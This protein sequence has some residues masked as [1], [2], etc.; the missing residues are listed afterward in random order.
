MRVDEMAPPA[1]L[2]SPRPLTR[3][4]AASPA[5]RRRSSVPRRSL[6]K[7]KRAPTCTSRT[8]SRFTRSSLMKTS[9]GVSE[10]S[11]VK[12]T[13]TRASMPEASIASSRWRSVWIIFGARSG[14]RTLRGCGSKL[15]T[16]LG[17]PSVVVSF[18]PHPLKVLHPERAP[19]MIQTLRQR[20]EAIEASGIDALVLVPFTRDFSL[21]PAE[22]FIKEL[23]V[24]RLAVREVHVGERFIFGRDRLGTLDLLRA[25]GEAA[26]FRVSGL[27]DVSDAGGAISST[28]IRNALHDGDAVTAR[29]LLGLSL[30]H[31]SEPTRPY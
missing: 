10:K 11:R 6:P 17:A 18:D 19:K 8:A 4:P 16:T 27:G 24:K 29:E 5:A 9:A 30:I 22:V 23:L 14:C 15:T 2:T 7:M 26:G 12:G 20:E 1:S 13:R 25:A 3:N 21:T 28:R 31:I